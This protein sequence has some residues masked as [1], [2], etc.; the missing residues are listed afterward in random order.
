MAGAKQGLSERRDA[1]RHL[2]EEQKI[3]WPDF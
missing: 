1:A 3:N 2:N